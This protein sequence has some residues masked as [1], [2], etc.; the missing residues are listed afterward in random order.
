MPTVEK[1]AACNAA[2]E[3]GAFRSGVPSTCQPRTTAKVGTPPPGG[4]L[5]W[6]RQLA[7]A[8]ETGSNTSMPR[9]AVDATTNAAKRK[10]C[11]G[12]GWRPFKQETRSLVVGGGGQKNKEKWVLNPSQKQISR[13]PS[14]ATSFL[15]CSL[16][17]GKCFDLSLSPRRRGG[18]HLREFSLLSAHPSQLASSVRVCFGVVFLATLERTRGVQPETVAVKIFN[19][20]T[21]FNVTDEQ[22]V[23][24]LRL[25]GKEAEAI[26]DASD[27]GANDHVV[28][29]FGLVRGLATPQWASALG[30]HRD[31]CIRRKGTLDAGQM[32][33]L[34]TKFVSGGSLRDLLHG[35]ETAG[36]GSR[37]L[38]LGPRGL[39]LGPA[40]ANQ[41]PYVSTHISARISLLLQIAAALRS[42]HELPGNFL[43]HGDLKPENIL[44]DVSGGTVSVK[45]VDFGLALYKPALNYREQSIFTAADLSTMGQGTVF[46]KCPRLY[47]QA[48]G[49]AARLPSRS[50]DI[51]AFGT[52]AWEVLSGLKPWDGLSDDE[53]RAAL[54]G[55]AS[56][57]TD[58]LSPGVPTEVS[59]MIERCLSC[60]SDG[61]DGQPRRPR[62]EDV[63]FDL[64]G[65]LDSFNTSASKHFFFSFAKAGQEAKLVQYVCAALREEG[66]SIGMLPMD[67]KAGNQYTEMKAAIMSA[68][69]FVA[70]VSPA[71]AVHPVCRMELDEALR[72][73]K[74]VIACLTKEGPW[75]QWKHPLHSSAGASATTLSSA[76][77]SSAPPLLA[78]PESSPQHPLVPVLANLYIDLGFTDTVNWEAWSESD[79]EK[80][81][82]I[83]RGVSALPRLL[84]FAK[85]AGVTPLKKY[86]PMRSREQEIRLRQQMAA[87]L[88]ANAELCALLLRQEQEEINLILQGPDPEKRL[89]QR[90]WGKREDAWR[91][92][93]PDIAAEVQNFR[94]ACRAPGS[95]CASRRCLLA[96]FSYLCIISSLSFFA[97]AIA[98]AVL[99]YLWSNSC[100]GVGC[101][102]QGNASGGSD[103][104]VCLSD[105]TQ[106][107]IANAS[108]FVYVCPDQS[109]CSDSMILYRWALLLCVE[110]LIP[111]LFVCCCC[112]FSRTLR[113]RCCA[114]DY[115]ADAEARE[116]QACVFLT[117][118]LCDTCCCVRPEIGIPK[119]ERA[120]ASALLLGEEL[121]DIEVPGRSDDPF[122][123]TSLNG[124][125]DAPAF[126]S[127]H[128]VA[129]S[130][131]AY[132]SW[133][134]AT[135]PDLL[136]VHA[137][138][139]KSSCSSSSLCWN[140][141]SGTLR[142]AAAHI[143]LA[144][145]ALGA[146]VFVD[147]NLGLPG[148]P[149]I[150][151]VVP[152]AVSSSASPSPSISPS[153]SV[154][155][156]TT[157]SPTA[158]WSTSLTHSTTPS[159]SL[160]SSRS[161]TL[162]YSS[163][164]SVS[165]SSVASATLTPSH[166]SSPSP[167]YT[168]WVARASIQGWTGIS[169]DSSGLLLAATIAFSQIEVNEDG[170]VGTWSLEA[171]PLSWA[172]IAAS[173]NGVYLLAA[174]NSD[175]YLYVNSNRPGGVW[176]QIKDY[177]V[178]QWAAVSMS[179]SGQFAAAAAGS[180]YIYVSSSFGA[181]GSW[182]QA[183]LSFGPQSWTG[184][185]V[186]GSGASI[187]ATTNNIDNGYIFALVG[188]SWTKTTAP[189]G[190][191]GWS[192]VAVSSD[193]KIVL[194]S[195][196]PGQLFTNFNGGL[197][198]WS[199]S[200]LTLTW[201][202]VAVSGDGSTLVAAS[203]GDG[204]A[205][206]VSRTGY[207]IAPSWVNQN[208]PA[209]T[210]W[211]GV[212]SSSSGA[213]LAASADGNS[214]FTLAG[215]SSTRK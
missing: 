190:T 67:T 187:L 54:S 154:S 193:G 20:L 142:Q 21:L 77:G 79:N 200:G 139:N 103:S 183:A 192:S 170:G 101:I 91:S 130:E 128:S 198:A 181:A 171:T 148:I 194:A 14:C 184:I 95:S 105:T 141:R 173:A 9:S 27:E 153:L 92:Q 10:T 59:A 78:I 19:K 124:A 66:F 13:P 106:T 167:Q 57:P 174:E 182:Q 6:L 94:C 123:G 109:P 191:S 97:L 43:V 133:L 197:G 28:K 151:A 36:S 118:Y 160:S 76:A 81:R 88:K 58:E 143:L 140:A 83:T 85:T 1:P 144:L 162:F 149:T 44:L 180:D 202:A 69:I 107:C 214:I 84:Q 121:V 158:S 169:S 62:A 72:Q 168:T 179:E 136:R 23:A 189:A 195:K 163:S 146:C 34:V 157:C 178:A 137:F 199:P 60:R 213:L 16:S 122:H 102:D 172:S 11:M 119:T 165:P 152:V 31:A 22:Y 80:V 100:P 26:K 74:K 108:S 211:T 204:A 129:D 50:S 40:G 156:S 86:G 138:K 25:A 135:A 185:S 212:T 201:A 46:Y 48:D 145:I 209:N 73:K 114:K 49:T 186:S 3:A 176:T 52:I 196:A 45:L 164:M 37:S 125:Y 208:V 159:P 35:G 161:P 112:C 126:S 24:Y 175:G 75:K 15:R 68:S 71:Y 53:R 90:E 89:R 117:C 215:P 99:G 32:C 93:R 120:G 8:R 132:S 64:D 203:S 39:Q 166:S 47:P 82:R 96:A 115:T 56:L 4:R 150:L 33:G 205:I 17:L 51:F 18:Q 5:V 30:N 206:F 131:T 210:T 65:A 42:L 147:S 2:T 63:W 29:S 177:R 116:F 188:G 127:A 70:F 98:T 104:V 7:F 41:P 111:S 110:V 38:T 55:G 155:P 61:P 207:A 12:L 134:E 113:A 87:G